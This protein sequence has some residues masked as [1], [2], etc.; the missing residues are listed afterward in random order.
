MRCYN[1][2]PDTALQTSLDRAKQARAE[3]LARG[4]TV[5]YFPAEGMFGVFDGNYQQVGDFFCDIPSARDA[6]QENTEP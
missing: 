3:L 4:F 1:G 5:T 2:C 6:L